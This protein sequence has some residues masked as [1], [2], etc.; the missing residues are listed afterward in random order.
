M[1]GMP[2]FMSHLLVELLPAL[3][4][5]GVVLRWMFCRQN[6]CYSHYARHPVKLPTHW[7]LLDA[8][9][10]RRKPEWVLREVLRLKA[11]MGQ[12]VGC[13][14]VACTF[15]RLH[16][17]ATVGKTFVAEAIKNHQYLLMRIARDLRAK[18]PLPVSINAV[19]GIDLTFQTDSR[20]ELHTIFG[21][22]DH[23]SR[24]CT[25]LVAVLN[26]RSWTLLGH[27]C[28]AIGK[29][30]KPQAIRADNEVIFRSFVFRTFL[31]LAG[32]R[33]QTIPVA[34]PWC[35][36]RCERM[37]R[38][39]KES[40][41]PLVISGK[42]GLQNALLEFARF[43]NQVRTHQNL[44]GLTPAEAWQGL[45]PSDIEQMPVKSAT[46]VQAL[47]GVLVGYHLRR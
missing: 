22:I 18:T 1:R 17:P 8:P 5:L 24:V 7:A 11:L 46:L 16:A 3:V 15:N 14:K 42:A 2:H 27:L 32:I 13:R 26:K 43:Y 44:D 12:R 20:A 36:G 41:G 45:T 10:P 19:W 21:V 9:A 31:K 47:D 38:S 30:G 33:R 4:L 35:N 25:R 23:G 29:Y 34:A 37:F 39:L 40:L 28:L 6:V